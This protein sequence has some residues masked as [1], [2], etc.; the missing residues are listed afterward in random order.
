MRIGPESPRFLFAIESIWKHAPAASGVF[1][2]CDRGGQYLYFGESD[3][4]RR[5][6]TALLNT[7]E[8]IRHHRPTTFTFELQAEVLRA[9]RR[10]DLLLTYPTPCN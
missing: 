3:N 1:A 6:L 8:C 4:I 2:L 10:N 5:G 9:M 7:G